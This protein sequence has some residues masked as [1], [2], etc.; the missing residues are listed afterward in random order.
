MFRVSVVVI[1]DGLIDIIQTPDGRTT[2][3]PGGAAV[4]VAV[5]LARLGESVA[6]ARP[7]SNDQ[8][9][10]NLLEFTNS[11]K[12]R[13]IALPGMAATGWA[14]ARQHGQ[15]V[16]YEFSDEIRNR[17]YQ[18]PETTRLEFSQARVVAV[19]S[20]PFDD[21]DA[22]DDVIGLVEEFGVSLALDPNVRPALLGELAAYREGFARAAS[23]ADLVRTSREDLEL[24]YPGNRDPA[25]HFAEKIQA[26]VVESNGPGIVSC[27]VDGHTFRVAPPR[28]HGPVATVGA[29]DAMFA[30][31]IT[32]LATPRWP[33][34]S[35]QWS[36]LLSD[37]AAAAAATC[38]S[39]APMIPSTFTLQRNRDE[40][41]QQDTRT[42]HS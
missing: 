33:E 38:L 27:F 22:V 3:Q 12:V 34:T 35:D 5:N 19:S 26:A 8:R 13:T 6:L 1:G 16:D 41:V 23:V 40:T 21:A 29:G 36:S 9:G 10:S 11:H 42:H 17:R 4:N 2:E 30:R 24:L 32:D 37:S 28:I 39:T 25:R 15:G 31:L 14:L 20:F 7:C 18:I